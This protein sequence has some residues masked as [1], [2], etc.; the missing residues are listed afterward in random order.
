MSKVRD[1]LSLQHGT[2]FD[3]SGG[4]TAALPTPQQLLRV[5]SFDGIPDLKLQRMHGIAEA[6]SRGDL[7]AVRIRAMEP[8]EAMQELQR[9]EGIGPFSG[10]GEWTFS[11]QEP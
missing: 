11:G 3:V 4:K 1:R 10:I 7:D 8:E 6:A 5:E 2:V 9:L